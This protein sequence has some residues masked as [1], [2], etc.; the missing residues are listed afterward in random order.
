MVDPAPLQAL[1]DLLEMTVGLLH[2]SGALL[3]DRVG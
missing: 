3:P 1:H 2:A